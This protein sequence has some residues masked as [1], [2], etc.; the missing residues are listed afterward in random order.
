ML[1]EWARRQQMK[2]EGRV[3]YTG[4][5]SWGW[6]YR[7]RACQD[8]VSLWTFGVQY[9]MR[10]T[11]KW[12]CCVCECVD[13][14]RSAFSFQF[15]WTW[16]DISHNCLAIAH[17]CYYCS[18]TMTITRIKIDWRR[19]PKSSR[20]VLGIDGRYTV[21][22][23]G[24]PSSRLG[25]RDTDPARKKLKRTDHNWKCGKNNTISNV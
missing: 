22:I 12:L 20:S 13:V 25:M 9:S 16:I 21:R 24:R 1:N 15:T 17:S 14:C 4:S 6:I 23:V 8:A 10:V 2:P 7:A 3:R 5:R 19:A 11:V 18:I